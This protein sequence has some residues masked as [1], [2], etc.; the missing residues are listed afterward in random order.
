MGSPQQFHKHGV[1]FILMTE[2]RSRK[3]PGKNEMQV[4]LVCQGGMQRVAPL[5]GIE[6]KADHKIR[7][8]PFIDQL[9]AVAD[10]AHAIE[11]ALR[12]TLEDVRS[13]GDTFLLKRGKGSF[14]QITRA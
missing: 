13:G 8:Y 6:M 11:K 3:G 12:L 4:I 2:F 7:A 1:A 10:F 9:G 5:L 14:F